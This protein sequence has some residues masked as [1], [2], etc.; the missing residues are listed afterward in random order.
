MDVALVTVFVSW[1]SLSWMPQSHVQFCPRSKRKLEETSSQLAQL[2]QSR[3]LL[4]EVNSVLFK[5]LSAL[6]F[7]GNFFYL[8]LYLYSF[9]VS[10]S[11]N[12]WSKSNSFRGVS[13][14]SFQ[15][16]KKRLTTPIFFF[17]NCRPCPF[18]PYI[19]GNLPLLLIA[20]ISPYTPARANECKKWN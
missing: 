14:C 7:P 12:C 6:P 18:P 13:H 1:I 15:K 20:D 19:Y 5:L 16:R 4:K 3:N 10:N 9:F 2:Q 17:W 8:S 11:F